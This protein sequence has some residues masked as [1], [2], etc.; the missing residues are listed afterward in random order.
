MHRSMGRSGS[1]ISIDMRT[2]EDC[3][4]SLAN[5]YAAPE[6][7]A[8]PCNECRCNCFTDAEHR[9][10]CPRGRATFTAWDMK[11]AVVVFK[12]PDGT[13]S[14]PAR[15]DKKTPPGCERITM[16]SLREVE[17]HERV[18]GVR[19]EIVHFDRG[20]GNGFDTRDLPRLPVDVR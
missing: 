10:A 12:K 17:R 14:Y 16:R 2:C 4:H 3:H 19:S 18:A 15:N 11:D 9:A 1:A 8:R 5:H 7:Y 20:S 13:F 6:G